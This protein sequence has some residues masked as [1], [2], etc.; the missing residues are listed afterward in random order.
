MSETQSGDPKAEHLL[1]LLYV[2]SRFVPK[3]LAAARTRML[4]S[5]EQGYVPAREGMG[6]MQ[7]NNL[8]SMDRSQTTVTPKN[9]CGWQPYKRHPRQLPSEVATS[10]HS[11]Q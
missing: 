6:E 7:L 10:G 4:K 1:A 11:S 5:A 8:S 3:D 2:E 9:G